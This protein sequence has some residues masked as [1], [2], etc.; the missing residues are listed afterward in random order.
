M[1]DIYTYD[2]LP[3]PLKVQIWQIWNDIDRDDYIS[4]GNKRY[5][6]IVRILR[7]E[8]GL[9]ILSEPNP[10]SDFYPYH[11]EFE[12]FFFA[13]TEIEKSLDA[14]ELFFRSAN[15]VD[16]FD[17]AVNELNHRF[18]EHGVGY[19]YENGQIIRIDSQL[20][21]EKIVRPAL[22]LL[23]DKH[24]AGAEQEFLKAH[25][26]YRNGNSKEALNECLKSFESVMKAICKKREWAYSNNATSKTLIQICL[27]NEL[28]PHFWQKHYSSLEDLLKH[29]VPTARNKLSGHGQGSD[30][31]TV[32]DYL[33]AYMLHMTASAIV[34]LI[35][36]EKNL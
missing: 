26:H 17:D 6:H 1:P 2:K 19:Q 4:R 15:H 33:V 36:A 3:N 31:E 14:V 12:N 8:Y 32:P 23:N 21:H 7:R 30:I 9:F 24:Y 22:Q 20:I 16:I 29:S 28:I 11:K 10:S 25:E 5:E 13:E 27:K 18:K 35:E 34:F